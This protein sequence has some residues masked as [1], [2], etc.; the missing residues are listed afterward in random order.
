MTAK[1]MQIVIEKI[2]DI[3]N[4]MSDTEKKVTLEVPADSGHGDYATNIALM[5]AKDLGMPPREVAQQ[6]ISKIGD[7]ANIA[8]VEI[9]GPGF[10]NL[11]LSNQAREH[12]LREMQKEDY[13][14]S[15]KGEGRKI[16]LEFISAN[17]TGPLTILG[18][19]HAF[20]GT[21]LTNCLRLQGYQV[22]P[23]YYMNNA[24]N[25]IKMLGAATAARFLQLKGKEVEFKDEYY[26][27]EYIKEIAAD[28]Q[29]ELDENKSL[30][31]LIP[32]AGKR[33]SEIII[34]QIQE[35]IKKMGVEIE[36]DYEDQLHKKGLVQEAF[37]QLV[38]EGYTANEEGA[39][40]L[41]T[42]RYGDEKNRVLQRK[43]GGDFTY[44]MADIAYLKSKFDS[45]ASKA[46]IFFGADHHDYVK[47]VK[48][49]A[50]VLGYKGG[51]E[52]AVNQ[53]VRLMK[54]GKE[55]KMSKRAGN[56][57]LSEDLLNEVPLDVIKYFF[58]DKSFTSH[59]DFD[60][61]KAKDKSENNPVYYIQYAHARMC[62][63][64][65][66]VAALVDDG[67]LDISEMSDTGFE[68]KQE[69]ELIMHLSK[70][71]S[72]VDDIVEKYDFQKMAHFTLDAARLFS[73]FYTQHK[74]IDVENQKETTKRLLVVGATKNVIAKSLGLMGISAPEK[75]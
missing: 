37:D 58:L 53:M 67:Q 46:I 4:Q 2:Q 26:Q 33:A 22:D 50:E 42:I 23:R 15:N 61:D 72:I 8:K 13:G 55:F 68:S 28:I 34:A 51:V 17:P 27:G 60:L 6:I 73:K 70:F 16:N 29:S 1:N 59:M 56:F 49:A 74:V 32:Q 14:A 10:I 21:L 30:E 5:L 39:V 12:M 11:T 36:Y 63:I 35:I 57:V 44:R 24:G 7:D 20:P 18:M 52:C 65:E 38:S 19:R 25:Q 69:R 31:E 54:D 66:K 40:W 71:E 47:D 3:V 45:G 75:M 62:S 41:D 64:E 43:D 48:I 9:A